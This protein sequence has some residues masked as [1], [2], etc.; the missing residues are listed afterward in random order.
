MALSGVHFLKKLQKTSAKIENRTL[1]LL[2]T[3]SA[4]VYIIFYE[5]QIFHKIFAVANKK[6]FT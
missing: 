2:V 4:L 1:H 3:H 6:I 5:H